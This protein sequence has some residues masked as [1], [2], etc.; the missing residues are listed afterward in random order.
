MNTYMLLPDQEAWMFFQPEHR[1]QNHRII[2]PR[3][4]TEAYRIFDALE[5]RKH[6]GKPKI[7]DTDE[8]EYTPAEY[9]HAIE[10]EGVP[11]ER[12]TIE[13]KSHLDINTITQFARILST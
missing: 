5:H 11:R 7:T 4:Q 6:A 12:Y 13:I 8:E 1:F 3:K 10:E 9:I 2:C